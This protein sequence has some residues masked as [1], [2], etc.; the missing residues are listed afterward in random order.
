MSSDSSPGV[1][2]PATSLV[3]LKRLARR[4]L[5]WLRLN[6][7][8]ALTPGVSLAGFNLFVDDRP[9]PPKERSRYALD[10]T[11][12]LKPSTVLDVGSGG[13]YHALAFAEAGAQVLCIDYGTSIYARAAAPGPI[14]VVHADFNQFEPPQ[15]YGLVWSSHVLEHQ[16]DVGRFIDKLI[17]CCADDG[18]VCITVPD[19]HRN[20]WG[21]HLTL[22]SPGLLAY[23]VVLCGVDLSHSRLIRGTNEF[24]L[25]FQPKRV[26]L[27]ALSFDNGDLTLLAQF[28]PAG[29]RENADPWRI[30]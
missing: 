9:G 30:W 7:R 26:T 17:E 4:T 3:G 5:S 13:G 21:G 10:A 20:L 27:P 29:F 25:L 23:N 11:L 18:H 12:A 16:R 8:Y 22:W 14:Q 15:R 2:A 24:S 6:V 28:L 1:L 19:P